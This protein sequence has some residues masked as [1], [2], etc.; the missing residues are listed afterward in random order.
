MKEG[1][2]DNEMNKRNKD[3]WLSIS[4][5]TWLRSCVCDECPAFVI[6]VTD[7]DKRDVLLEAVEKSF[8]KLYEDLRYI[9]QFPVVDEDY[10]TIAYAFRCTTVDYSISEDAVRLLLEKM[11]TTEDVFKITK[12]KEYKAGDGVKVL[13]KPTGC[14]WLLRSSF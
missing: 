5:G 9:K 8:H 12:A 2:K 13:A 14:P 10:E 4:Y 3:E 1:Y 11:I 6:E 7:E